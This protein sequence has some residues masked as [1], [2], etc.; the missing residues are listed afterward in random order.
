MYIFFCSLLIQPLNGW[1]IIKCFYRNR[2]T[3]LYVVLYI[4]LWIRKKENIREECE[5]LQID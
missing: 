2:N 5:K 4:N 1:H 3:H